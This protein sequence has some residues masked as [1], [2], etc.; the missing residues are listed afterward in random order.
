MLSVSIKP[1]G[2]TSSGFIG[3]L[4]GL[5]HLSLPSHCPQLPNDYFLEQI[6]LKIL[7]CNKMRDFYIPVKKKNCHFSPVS[8]QTL[9]S[10]QPS[11][12]K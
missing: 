8:K 11:L 1:A 5:Q 12:K 2:S 7:H 9:L 3:K 10:C 4:S 6:A